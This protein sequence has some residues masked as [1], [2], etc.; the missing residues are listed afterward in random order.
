MTD[1]AADLVI[2]DCTAR[3]HDEQEGIAFV[4]NTTIVVAATAGESRSTRL[5]DE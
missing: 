3:V 4:E 5:E 1:P 2:T